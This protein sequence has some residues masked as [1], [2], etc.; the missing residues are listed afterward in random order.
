[1]QV[2]CAHLLER[3]N[4]IYDRMD[5]GYIRE[6][7]DA[8]ERSTAADRNRPGNDPTFE[9]PAPRT[10]MSGMSMPHAPTPALVL[11]LRTVKFH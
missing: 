11:A 1:M 3:G 8:F 10:E 4:A 9:G 5:V 6:P 2:G 7:V